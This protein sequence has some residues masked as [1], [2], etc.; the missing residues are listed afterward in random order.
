MP[1][2]FCIA[3]AELIMAKLFIT[4]AS[5]SGLLA[6][7]LGAFGAHA[8]KARLDDYSQGVWETAVQYHFYHA[9]ALL[10]VGI[11]ALGQ[12]QSTLLRSSGWLFLLGTLIFSGSL[13]LLALSGTRWLGA[14][15]PLGGLA[16]IAGWACL[17]VASWKLIG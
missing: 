1:W 6:V 10:A 9:L 4:L 7:T 2:A 11:V 14:V 8:L 16:F 15:T 17:A 5:V 3:Q 13:Y 12:P